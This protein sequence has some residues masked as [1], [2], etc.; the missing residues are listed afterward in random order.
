MRELS[1]REKKILPAL[2]DRGIPRNR[3]AQMMG[4]NTH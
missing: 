3:I 2:D 4:L 1:A